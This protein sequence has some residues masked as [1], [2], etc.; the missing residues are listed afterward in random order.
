M[1]KA[2]K[3]SKLLA[4]FLIPV[5][6]GLAL[7]GGGSPVPTAAAQPAGFC[8]AQQAA[9]DA[10]KAQITAHNAQPHVFE[11]PRQQAAFNAYNAEAASLEAQQDAAL[12][13][14]ESCLDAME[15]LEDAGNTSLPLKPLPDST[16]Q[17]LDQAKAKVPATWTPRAAPPAGRRWEVPRTDPARRVYDIL[18]RDNPARNL[19]NATLQGRPRPVA[20]ARDPAYPN[21]VI[22]RF[23]NGAS[24]VHADHIVPLAEIVNMPNFMKLSPENMWA[25]TR[26]PVNLQWLSMRANTAKSSLSVLDMTA[27]DPAWQ[28][29]QGALQNQVRQQLQDMINKLLASQV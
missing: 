29:S 7:V 13:K 28:A 14:V 2:T 21:G 18:R 27:V 26:A 10:I 20:G 25:L 6:L 22:G 11:L 5:L 17:Q 19:G 24:K 12:A 16:R 3:S 8:A 4:R 23:P 15:T 9:F 1:T